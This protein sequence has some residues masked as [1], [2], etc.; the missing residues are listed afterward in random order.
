[1]IYA[2]VKVFYYM[3]SNTVLFK[4]NTS[5]DEYHKPETTTNKIKQVY[6]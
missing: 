5:K 2:V 1:M 3:R 6:L 4:G